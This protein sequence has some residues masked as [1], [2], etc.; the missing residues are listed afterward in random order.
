MGYVLCFVGRDWS[1][2]LEATPLN[3]SSSLLSLFLSVQST[4][5][6]MRE[7]VIICFLLATMLTESACWKQSTVQPNG[8]T[9]ASLPPLLTESRTTIMS[10]QYKCYLKIIRDPPYETKEKVT[11]I[12]TEKGRW[13]QHPMSNRTWTNYT[14]CTAYTEGKQTTALN[15]YYVAITGHGISITCLL[16]SLCIFF[17][18]KSLSCQRI[19]LHKS[20]FVSYILNSIVTIIWLSAVANNKELV[21]RNPVGCKILLFIHLYL[22]G[23]NY[24]WMLCEGVYL[25]TLIIVAAF[26]EEQK[27]FWY[28]VLGWGFPLIPA[29]IHA[30]ARSMYYNDNCW[31][32]SDTVL[33]YIIHGP[34]CAALLVNL[35]FLLNIVRVLIT[36]L[37]VT[38]QMQ[39]KVYM[40]VVRATLILVPL[41]GIQ[42]IL[43]P[44]RPEGQ[45]IRKIYDHV[46][47]ISA[48]YQGLLVT[49]IFCFFNGE[50]QIALKKHWS[51]YK[52]QSSHQF[53]N[54]DGCHSNATS[55]SEINRNSLAHSINNNRTNGKSWC[56]TIP[57]KVAGNPV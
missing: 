52:D 2:N 26:V 17:H 4:I 3:Q 15:L 31:M 5:P 43:I 19:S 27:L 49:L 32:S 28:Y 29:I 34:I 6:N 9:M 21:E 25:H 51:K 20:L 8:E 30:V 42:F 16:V 56:E 24:F 54:M 7:A 37:K 41:M 48:H 33:L 36:K 10:A 22:I 1:L 13:F 18:F 35:L 39:S 46:M 45:L 44:S 57:L 12:C 50:V 14:Q 40:K 55:T 11:K 47:H 23:C 53:T 38:H